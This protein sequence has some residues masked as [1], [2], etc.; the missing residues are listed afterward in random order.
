M[1]YILEDSK[2]II[3]PNGYIHPE[4]EKIE[5]TWTNALILLPISL[6]LCLPL[7]I[8]NSLSGL[9]YQK[10]CPQI[11]IPHEKRIDENP[12]FLSSWNK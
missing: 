6:I 1:E 3:L 11:I 12:D 7:Y 2:T 10:F 8:I 5:F 9:G 4:L